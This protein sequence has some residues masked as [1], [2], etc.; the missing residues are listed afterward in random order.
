M[1]LNSNSENAKPGKHNEVSGQMKFE[2]TNIAKS[3]SLIFFLIFVDQF[4]KYLILLRGGFYVCNES[5]A[6]SL[7]LKYN[8]LLIFLALIALLIF[9]NSKFKGQNAKSQFKIQ[10]YF[11]FLLMLSGGLSNIIDRLRFGCVFDFIDLGF[12]PLFNLADVFITTGAIIIL[13]SLLKKRGVSSR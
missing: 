7:N 5:L 3:L 12:W 10:Y 2:S 8:L 6:F 4:F 11:S 9:I 1:F 13:A